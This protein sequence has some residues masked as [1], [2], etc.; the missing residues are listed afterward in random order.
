MTQPLKRL[1]VLELARVL[2]G[3]WAGQV[4]ADLGADVIKVESP[5]GDETRGWG[6][7]F[8]KDGSAAYFHSTNR[9]KKSVIADFKKPED[10]DFVSAL[11]SKADIIIENFKVGGLSRFKLDYKSIKV[12]NPKII[13]CSITGFGQNGPYKSR[14]G[15]DFI[16]QAMGGIMDLTGEE[17]GPPQKPGIAYADIFTGLYSVIAILSSLRM[18][19]ETGMGSHID[20]SLFD[21][22]LGVLANQ[23]S[24]YLTTGKIPK[25]MGNAHPVIVPYQVF[26]V[27]DGSI[28]I[29]C[30]NDSQF[31]K[32]CAALG[33]DL[34]LYKDF[35]EN[36]LRV[37]NRDKLLPKI[38]DCLK[39]L[40][41]KEV[42][43]KMERV[44]VPA[45]PINNIEEALND[46]QSKYRKMKM[47]YEEGYYLNNPIKFNNLSLA[48]NPL[49]Q[50]LGFDTEH[51]KNLVNDGSFWNDE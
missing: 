38:N 10:L 20:M 48:G 42:L 31:K 13:Y 6:P 47:K 4:L 27:L 25:R 12:V 21:T 8:N 26:S 32:M 45:G 18:A 1:R 22:Q 30:G 3:P 44:G 49:A 34:Y 23:A 33:L 40:T 35:K 43:T 9:G 36:H 11:A 15:Y 2:A 19:K 7:P 50:G 5:S 17:N 39:N 41:K 37:K 29:A 14:A 51:I 46:Q 24:S 16:I 28:V